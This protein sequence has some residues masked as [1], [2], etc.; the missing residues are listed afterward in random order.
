MLL[1]LL[2][3]L[4]RFDPHIYNVVSIASIAMALK[5]AGIIFSFLF[6]LLLARMLGSEGAG[7]FFLALAIMTIATVIGRLGLDN[8]L[9]R[10]VAAN[11]SVGN[12][13]AVA[14]VYAKGMRLALVTSTLVAITL[15]EIAPWL[16]ETVFNKPTALTPVRW[17]AIAVMPM[18]LIFLHSETLKGLKRVKDAILVQGVSLPAFAVLALLFVGDSYGLFGAVA[19][20]LFSIIF[21]LALGIFLWR[22]ATPQLRQIKGKFE[23]SILLASSIPL[24]CVAILGVLNEWTSTFA[25]G[26]WGL[27]EDV[28]ILN[29]ASRT[30]SL[31]G[32]PLLAVNTIAAPKFAALFQTEQLDDLVTIVGRISMVMMIVSL[33]L[34]LVFTVVPEWIMS[35][36]GQE[37]RRGGHLLTI[38]AVGQFVN[39]TVGP[40]G[41]LLVMSGNEPLLRNTLVITTII[42]LMLN[43]LL[44]PHWGILGAAIAS[45]ATLAIMNLISAY[46][47]WKRLQLIPLP[48]WRK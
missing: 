35:W 13:Q 23:T 5:V 12:W 11:A 9:L 42:S 4:Y 43:F 28:G 48:A 2:D 47:V 27:K 18:A 22:R 36:Y 40:V 15:Y 38:L 44:V 16:A 31:L 30:A 1:R 14:G 33:P 25:L 3:R 37:F 19:A 32:L 39:V 6:N 26:I 41:P 20:Y 8:A 34:L 29:I 46:Y 21:T 7:I 24:F 45:S 17:F 10:F